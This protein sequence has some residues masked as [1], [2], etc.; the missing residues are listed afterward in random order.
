MNPEIETP[1]N[2]T[3]FS[4]GKT[5]FS[6]SADIDSNSLRLPHCAVTV[7]LR[8]ISSKSA[9]LTSIVTVLP[10]EPY[11]RAPAGLRLSR[12]LGVRPP[13]RRPPSGRQSDRGPDGE[14]HGSFRP[15]QVAPD[16]GEL[17]RP[18]RG[19]GRGER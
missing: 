19:T 13:G 8:E 4:I 11:R 12:G 9:N 18:D 7:R 1:N 17:L 6:N 10:R 3:A 16:I 15:Q 14:L 2:L 5:V